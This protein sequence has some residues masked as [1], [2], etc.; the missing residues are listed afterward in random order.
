MQ[1][2]EV[3]DWK[4]PKVLNSLEAIEDVA[5][6]M[7]LEAVGDLYNSNRPTLAICTD[8]NNF[9]IFI[10]IGKAIHYYHTFGGPDDAGHISTT[11]AMRLIAHFL[12]DVTAKERV[13]DYEALESVPEDSLLGQLAVPLLMAKK[14]AGAGEGLAEQLQLVRFLPP[15]EQ[16]EAA[17]DFIQAW[18]HELGPQEPP[19]YIQ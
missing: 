15:E 9:L 13:F 18:R 8:L 2:C 16:L 11:D 3:V 10:P 7:K 19:S 17:S 4:T 1:V 5:D 6:Q 12:T 14:L